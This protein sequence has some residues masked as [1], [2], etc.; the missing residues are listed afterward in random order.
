MPNSPYR[1]LAL[2]LTVFV[3]LLGPVAGRLYAQ[4]DLME[5]LTAVVVA[6][7]MPPE[8]LR[9]SAARM[10]DDVARI[11][12]ERAPTDAKVAAQVHDLALSMRR[13]ATLLLAGLLAVAIAMAAVVW[14]IRPRRV[15]A[16][17]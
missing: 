7:Q 13:T 3:C 5:T 2:T 4:S 6:S 10:P 8:R 14:M 11:L 12:A 15:V 16:A 9:E 1:L 17:T